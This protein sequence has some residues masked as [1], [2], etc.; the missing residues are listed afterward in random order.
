MVSWSPRRGFVDIAETG[1][2]HSQDIDGVDPTSIQ[3]GYGGFKL[4]VSLTRP[5]GSF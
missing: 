1:I 2:R 3:L 5:T 4:L